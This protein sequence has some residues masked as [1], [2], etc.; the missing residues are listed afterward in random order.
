MSR[1]TDS[2]RD[3]AVR[4]IGPRSAM[5]V[6]FVVVFG[7]GC[8]AKDVERPWGLT[9]MRI[10]HRAPPNADVPASD[11]SLSVFVPL[12]MDRRFFALSARDSL[13]V[14]EGAIVS[15]PSGGPHAQPQYSPIASFGRIRL[16]RGATAGAI[17]ALGTSPLE[18]DDGA[19]VSMFVKTAVPPRRASRAS[20]GLGLLD[21]VEPYSEEFRWTVEFPS[22]P[23]HDQSSRAGDA[24]SLLLYPG[25]YGSVVVEAEST[26]ALRSGQYF[27]ESLDVREGATV[28]V[29]NTSGPVYLWIRRSLALGAPFQ[30]Y[31][32]EPNILIGY[33]GAAAPSITA[34]FRG[35]LVAPNANVH[36]P[37][38][39]D[40]H[41]GAFFARALELADG[42]KVERHSFAADSST[43]APPL[44]CQRCALL[45][46]QAVL[47][48]CN[49]S[50]RAAWTSRA[51]FRSCLMSCRSPS[52]VDGD[53]C[54][55]ECADSEAQIASVEAQATFETCIRARTSIYVACE[56]R[57]GYRP[58]T[59]EKL[60]YLLET[61]G[62]GD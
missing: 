12:G 59:C 7:N 22:V 46:R 41:H 2:E 3:H 24:G 25:S 10:V 33:G 47:G 20:L 44:V 26:L 48:C 4:S 56:R 57:S 6:L 53:G 28:D 37:K 11:R 51:R 61:P 39:A 62:C 43:D 34:A 60:G 1:S 40:T 55:L 42:A 32:L 15:E 54:A 27:I 49:E 30:E 19:A 45:V 21:R 18:L 14:G 16:D 36:L 35:T 8:G 29:D 38:T 9:E 23:A 17:Y 52:V 13:V 58:G 31:V 50:N 5:L